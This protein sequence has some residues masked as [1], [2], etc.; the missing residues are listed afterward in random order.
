MLRNYILLSYIKNFLIVLTVFIGV[1]YAYI[2]GEVFILFKEKH[3]SIFLEYSLN[4]FPVIVFY[5][6]AFISSLALLITLRRFVQR[7]LDLVSQSFGLSPF[8][9]L[10]NAVLFTAFLSLLNLSMSYSFYPNSQKKLYRMEREYK[11]AK[12]SESGVVRNLWLTEKK[13][14]TVYF[15]G[16]QL[17]DLSSGKILNPF[18]LMVRGGSIQMVIEGERGLWKGDVITVKPAQIWDPRLDKEQVREYSFKF[19]DLSQVKPLAE[20]PEHLHLKDVVL[21]SLLGK[22]VGIN[23]RYYWYELI[24]R[25]LTS[26][27]PL[28]LVLLLSWLYL[29]K[30]SFLLGILSVI[31]Y[32]SAHWFLLNILRSIVE[33]TDLSLMY[34]LLLY[35]PLPLISLKGLYYMSKGIRV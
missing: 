33:N 11:K 7:K 18:I 8:D 4:F 20:K 23:H 32:F 29:R 27:L 30:K 16:F 35:I 2:F 5:T 13:E 1:V 17:V 28:N 31:S 15:Y 3:I 21:L 26:L 10:R 14:D 12:E 34:S 19:I 24:R 22:E 6:G 25:V 9:F